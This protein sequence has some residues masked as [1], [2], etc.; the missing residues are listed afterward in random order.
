MW[1]RTRPVAS[2][3]YS[4]VLY[5]SEGLHM[6]QTGPGTSAWFQFLNNSLGYMDVRIGP[7][8][9]FPMS[10]P[11]PP[12]TKDAAHPLLPGLTIGAIF[13]PS[14]YTGSP[15]LDADSCQSGMGAY[16]IHEVAYD[17]AGQLVR[18]AADFSTL[19]GT[20]GLR[21][22]SNV[23]LA[24]DELH[25]VAGRDHPVVEGSFVTLD[26]SLSWSPTS[27]IRSM[28]W[29][30]TSGPSFDLSACAK[31]VC[32]TYA[33]LVPAGGAVATFS[34]HV[35]SEA[36]AQSDATLALEVRSL[37][38]RQ[39][40]MHI[41][42]MG[43]IAFGI[44]QWFS[45]G[46]FLFPTRTDTGSIYDAQGPSRFQFWYYMNTD[47]YHGFTGLNPVTLS[48]GQ[49]V[50]L[51]PGKYSGTARGGYVDGPNPTFDVF[52]QGHGCSVPEWDVAL[53][54]L[55]RN[56]AD[57]TQVTQMA[58]SFSSRC[59]EG[60][61][62]EPPSYGRYWI[63]Y[64]PIQP[65][66]ALATGPSSVVAGASFTLK[67]AGSTAPRGFIRQITWRQMFGPAVTSQ[68]LAADSSLTVVTDP[69]TPD[70]SKLVYEYEVDDDWGQPSLALL[71]VVVTGGPT[72]SGS[73]PGVS[74][75][76]LSRPLVTRV[77]PVPSGGFRRQ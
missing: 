34:L 11:L 26:A 5:E 77:K 28:T 21:Y 13:Q 57:L 45:N 58:L 23:P 50:A 54:A 70:G 22:H 37:R 43:F 65:P 1:L 47:E 25:A 32:E 56:P 35:E 44:D 6:S 16:N 71:E 33:P 9:R 72:P 29:R 3:S 49:G 46:A 38:D 63:N 51:V 7:E 20:G 64:Q 52:F 76:A 39:S 36:G 67:D 24:V 17:N 59:A 75:K 61:P 31:G 48:S 10:Y 73:A 30:Q 69:L 68:S 55:D 66:Q 40:L 12:G 8:F 27:P 4:S 42:G 18:L 41:Q 53:A 60:G 19:C 74:G 2:N 62:D 15:T 14:G